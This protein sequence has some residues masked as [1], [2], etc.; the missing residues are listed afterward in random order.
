MTLKPPVF[1]RKQAKP[2]RKAYFSMPFSDVAKEDNGGK[3]G[4][5]RAMENNKLRSTP[6]EQ[7]KSPIKEQPLSLGG[8]HHVIPQRFQN[9]CE[10][11][12]AV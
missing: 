8:L 10:S 1:Y 12:T 11:V 3:G 7:N 4:P 6:R 9:C 5:P 2:Q